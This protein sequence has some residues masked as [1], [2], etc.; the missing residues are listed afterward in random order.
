M[1]LERPDLDPRPPGIGL[2]LFRAGDAYDALQGSLTDQFCNPGYRVGGSRAVAESHDHSALDERY[3][4]LRGEFLE[5][6]VG[7]RRIGGG[8]GEGT[9][10]TGAPGVVVSRVS[11]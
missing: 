10:P 4:V 9:V 5:L 7:S 3:C 8:G 11:G 1:F 6:C 2:G